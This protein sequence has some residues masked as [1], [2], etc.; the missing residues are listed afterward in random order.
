MKFAEMERRVYGF[1]REANKAFIQPEQVQDWLNDGARDIAQR[2]R[3]LTQKSEGNTTA[4]GTIPVPDDLF[5]IKR[6]SIGGGYVEIADDDLYDSYE[7][8][9]DTP[10]HTLSRIF[11]G[12]IETYPVQALKAFVLKYWRN[13]TVMVEGEDECDLPLELQPKVV[14]YAIAQ[15][16]LKEGETAQYEYHWRMFE[17]GLQPPPLGRQRLNASPLRIDLEP[18]PFD[19]SDATHI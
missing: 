12:S 2:Q 9:G 19:T 1:L 5:E 7:D 3:V 13:P 18:G 11:A 10:R 14:E 8:A 15:A 16:F 17:E 4:A 6:L